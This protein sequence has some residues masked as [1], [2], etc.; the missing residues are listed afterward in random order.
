[1]PDSTVFIIE[2]RE[3][4]FH[5]ERTHVVGETRDEFQIDLTTDGRVTHSTHGGM[6]IE[7]RAFWDGDVL[8]FDSLVTVGGE[9]GTNVVRYEIADGGKSL[10]ARERVEFQS[11]S[12]SNLWVFDRQ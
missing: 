8:V 3:P 1:M 9:K 11:Q 5:L 7:S 12:H 2:H 4:R 6:H 10:I